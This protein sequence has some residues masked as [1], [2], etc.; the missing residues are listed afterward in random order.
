MA[1]STAKL[2][3]DFRVLIHGG[4][5]VFLIG[6]E[7][8]A[9]FEDSLTKIIRQIYSYVT[10]NVENHSFSAVDVCEYAVKLLEDDP[11]YNA[12]K[13]SVFTSALDHVL[14]AS[15]MDGSNLAIGAAS[16]LKHSPNPVSVARIV[17]DHSSHNYLAGEAAEDLAVE[18]GL[19]QV[20][21]K[22]FF[23]ERRLEQFNASL[24]AQQIA[25]ESAKALSETDVQKL[26]QEEGG[27]K[28]TVGCVCMYNGHV[29]AATSTGTSHYLL[30]PL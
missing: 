4:A 28:G 1:T 24:Q 9:L 22:Y 5:F 17:M 16:L 6:E 8:V 2:P 3:V 26:L 23:T 11:L 25:Q 19:P 10:S 20:E 30:L 15:I 12:G 18:H 13:G 7:R 27:K 14:E 21:N 29:A